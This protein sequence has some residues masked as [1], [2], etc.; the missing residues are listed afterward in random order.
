MKSV[1]ILALLA[2]FAGANARM[3]QNNPNSTA[4]EKCYKRC[5]A[6][7]GWKPICAYN[8]S[9]PMQTTHGGGPSVWPSFCMSQCMS[10]YWKYS[11]WKNLVKLADLK[12]PKICKTDMW[13]IYYL[14]DQHDYN[15]NQAIVELCNPMCAIPSFPAPDLA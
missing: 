5:D 1:T 13:K 9:Y 14:N 2:L 11:E 6:T 12:L 3:L 7:V 15:Y 4:R 10:K 8:P